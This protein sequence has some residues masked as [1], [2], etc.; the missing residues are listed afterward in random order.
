MIQKKAQVFFLVKE[1]MG[2][3]TIFSLRKKE[4]LFFPLKET[5]G[6]AVSLFC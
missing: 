2:G 1:T 6:S 5:V 3:A 4:M